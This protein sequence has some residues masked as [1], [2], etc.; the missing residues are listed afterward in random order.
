MS[1]GSVFIGDFNVFP[2]L[3][4][5]GPFWIVIEQ[6]TISSKLGEWLP[7]NMV[8][9]WLVDTDTMIRIYLHPDAIASQTD[10]IKYAE[11]REQALYTVAGIIRNQVLRQY[12]QLPLQSQEF[13]NPPNTDTLNL[14]YVSETT[15]SSRY[16]GEGDTRG[17]R[18]ATLIYSGFLKA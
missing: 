14:S 9:G 1:S 8:N 6:D 11:A 18:C 2:S 16:I 5:V 10:P 3:S 13:S 4:S 15:Y 17:V 7:I 12:I